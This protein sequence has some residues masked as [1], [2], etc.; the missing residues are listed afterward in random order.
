[1]KI[2]KYFDFS[3]L[4]GSLNSLS[5]T[6]YEDFLRKPLAKKGIQND[7]LVL[8]LLVLIIGIIGTVLVY[9]VENMGGIL[10][11]A[12]GLGS[13]AQGPLL[14]MFLLGLFFPTANSKVT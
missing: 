5:G 8:K 7:G 10:P 14:G 6:I 9:L 2:R 4:S 11:L 13:V 3:M 12:I 1:M